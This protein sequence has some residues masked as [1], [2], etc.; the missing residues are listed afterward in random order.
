MNKSADCDSAMTELDRAQLLDI[1]IKV[2]TL[3]L[4]KK[5][6]HF[7]IAKTTKDMSTLLLF[8]VRDQHCFHVCKN[9]AFGALISHGMEH[10]AMVLLKAVWMQMA[11]AMEPCV[12]SCRRAVEFRPPV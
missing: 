7:R 12:G 1:N 11:S 10:W 4:A 6:K 9:M 5:S 8:P 2:R 3:M